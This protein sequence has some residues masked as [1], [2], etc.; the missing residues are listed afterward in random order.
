V[1]SESLTVESEDMT[2]TEPRFNR[3]VIKGVVSMA[4]VALDWCGWHAVTG[5]HIAHGGVTHPELISDICRGDRLLS[6]LVESL[7]KMTCHVGDTAD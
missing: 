2:L 1:Q 7:T 3:I 6:I 4:A 5:D